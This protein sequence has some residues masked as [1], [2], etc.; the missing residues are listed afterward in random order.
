MKETLMKENLKLYLECDKSLWNGE[1]QVMFDCKEN[2][3]QITYSC[4]KNI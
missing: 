3:K 1:D 2:S 4:Y